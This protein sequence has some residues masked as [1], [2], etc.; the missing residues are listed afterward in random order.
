MNSDTNVNQIKKADRAVEAISF[1]NGTLISGESVMF[2]P[3][4]KFSA[5]R[6]TRYLKSVIQNSR[7]T[8]AFLIKGRIFSFLYERHKATVNNMAEHTMDKT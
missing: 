7:N 1:Q 3:A 4:T 5:S 8:I 2:K 6:F